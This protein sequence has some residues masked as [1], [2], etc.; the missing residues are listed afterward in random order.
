VKE[1]KCPSCG[2]VLGKVIYGELHT[3]H[4]VN[5]S[6]ADLVVSCEC[7]AYKVWYTP[8]VFSS[9]MRTLGREIGRSIAD[10]MGNAAAR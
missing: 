4:K 5:T 1:W 9:V 7:G 8:V 3:N 10:G 6:G 2:R